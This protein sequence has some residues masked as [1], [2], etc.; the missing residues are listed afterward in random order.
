[1]TKTIR[2]LVSSA[3]RRVELIRC[4]RN[5]AAAMGI[6]LTIV[7]IDQ[8]PDLSSACLEADRSVRVPHC[9]SPDYINTVTALCREE[10]ID[11]LIPTIDTELLGYSVSAKEFSQ[12]GTT[13]SVSQPDLVRVAR[14]KISTAQLLSNAGADVARFAIL[15]DV[16]DNLDDWNTPLVLKPRDGS[17]S[18]GIE[19]VDTAS[20]IEP[21]LH[22]HQNTMVQHFVS[23][24]EYTV[25]FFV[26]ADGTL[27]SI[28]PHL[29]LEVRAGEV[30]KAVIRRHAAAED[31]VRQL[32]EAMPGARGALCLQAIVDNDGRAWV[33]EVNA[34]F[35]GGFPLTHR[36][37]APFTRWLLEEAAGQQ[38]DFDQQVTN[39]LLMLRYDAAH[40]VQP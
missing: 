37:G 28:V 3:G 31:L 20:D 38:P 21:A 13:V 25:N 39:E 17:N 32:V 23:G 33:L 16:L 4:F 26:D 5:D 35:G 29:R 30:A 34:R 24:D 2:L 18:V 8:N 27:Q 15:T 36:A 1:M 7:A 11:L 40:F 6:D 14:D 19:F 9:K 12:A 10:A 22:D